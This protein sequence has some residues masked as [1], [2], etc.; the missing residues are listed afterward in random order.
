M[1]HR[2]TPF[3]WLFMAIMLCIATVS[4]A[5][6][7][8]ENLNRGI[9]AVRNGTSN[10]VSWRWLGTEDDG[11]TF[12]LYRNGTKVNATPLSVCNY[13]DAGAAANASYTVKAVVSGVEQ[14][15][16][17]AVTPWASLYKTIALK[18]PAGGTNAS[19][20]YTYSPNDCSIGDVDGDGEHEIFVKWDPSNSKDNSQKGYTGNVYIDCYKQN[21]TFL[22]RIDLG[23]NIRAGAHYTQY[24]VYDFD[25]DGRAEMACKTAD[26]TKDGKGVIIGS[27][28]ASYA[29]SSGYVLSGPEFLTVFNGATGAAMATTNYTPARGTVSS[30]GDSYGNRV[31]RFISAVVY[32]DGKTPSMVFGRGY[33]TRLVR[34]AWDWKGGKLTQQ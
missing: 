18:L 2:F 4:F 1:N 12:N 16:S 3:K 20:S 27:S 23:K 32:L 26:G 17:E 33:Y 11:I 8:M 29:N 25:G 28:T 21:G 30:W 24:L 22:W 14:T 13:T 5:Q 31:D 34:S 7:Q 9:V 15:A 10:F 6:Y 19:G